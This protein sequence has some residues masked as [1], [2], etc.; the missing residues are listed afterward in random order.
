VSHS[1]EHASDA[2]A[3]AVRDAVAGRT[4]GR[5][6]P[7]FRARL[8]QEFQSGRFGAPRVPVPRRPW[9]ARPALW[10]PVA[11]GLLVVA[12]L[13][14]N[15]GPDWR[16]VSAH[17]DGSVHVGGASFAPEDDERIAA[18]LRRGGDVRIEGA[19][20][21]DLVAPGVLAVTLA[22]GTSMTLPATPG[23]WWSRAARARV[24]AGDAYF[25]TGRGFHGARLRV[26]TPEVEVLAVGTAFA[27]LRHEQGSCVCVMEGRVRVTT[28][29]GGEGR[30]A[31]E[32]VVVPEG[33]RRLVGVGG[34]AETLPILEDSV[35]R[36]HEQRSSVGSALER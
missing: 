30:E 22:P 21:L 11:A 17:G 35:H 29:S 20:T 24:D 8:K 4:H 33:M 6:D 32:S 2:A 13:V 23:R 9:F 16:V 3:R 1:G 26:S 10:L 34:S 18:A 5:P 31:R 12:G 7:A 14:A 19:V 15:R 25:S 36:L 28:L 27:V